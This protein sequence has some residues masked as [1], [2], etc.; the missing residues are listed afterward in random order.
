MDPPCRRSLVDRNVFVMK[1]LYEM[2]IEVKEI[3][4]IIKSI[5]DAGKLNLFNITLKKVS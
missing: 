3:Q 1:P 2:A 4:H 5:K